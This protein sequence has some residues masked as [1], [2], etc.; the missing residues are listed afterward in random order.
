MLVAAWAALR[1]KWMGAVVRM[2]R[3]FC[4][5][6]RAVERGEL[7]PPVRLFGRPCWTVEHVLAHVNARLQAALDET[8]T[9][10]KRVRRHQI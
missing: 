4:L 8:K 7:P 5:D 1:T 10:Q 3:R 9:T 2:T 6:K